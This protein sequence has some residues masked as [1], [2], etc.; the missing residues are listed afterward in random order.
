A[1]RDPEIPA[2][3][4]FAHENYPHLTV[5]GAAARTELAKDFA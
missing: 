1:F 2:M 4:G 3:L 5:M